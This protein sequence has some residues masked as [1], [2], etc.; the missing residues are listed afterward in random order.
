MAVV[1]I[2][3][4]EFR[5]NQKSWFDRADRGE[6]IVILRGK[7][8]SYILTQVDDDSFEL[9]ASMWE[10]IKQSRKS[11]REGKGVT[12]TPTETLDEFLDRV[13]KCTE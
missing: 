5:D 8:P 3:S 12:M 6:N 1:Q 9:S 4:R 2:T 13:G 11:I 7:K 10:R